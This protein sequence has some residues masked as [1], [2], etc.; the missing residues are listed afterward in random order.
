[1][2]QNVGKSS[3]RIWHR[4]PDIPSTWLCARCYATRY[5]APKK[6]FKTKQQQYEYLSKLFSGKGNPMFGD[7]ITNLG[8]KYT[9]ER[10][11]KVSERGKRWIAQHPDEHRKK[12]VLGALKARQLGLFGLPTTPEKYMEDTLKKQNI[13]YISQYEYT[14]GLMDF[15]LPDGNIALFVDGTVWH[16]DPVIYSSEDVLFFGKTAKQ[17]WE[18]DLRQIN[19]LKSQGYAVLRFW[20]REIK[21]NIDKCIRIII[22]AIKR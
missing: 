9:P 21:E 12:A 7:H 5:Y 6:K 3:Y 17:I 15:Y 2:I 16:A 22:E 18:K 8:R 1:M 20:D 11:K 10:N 14:I 4:N 19:Y 13:K